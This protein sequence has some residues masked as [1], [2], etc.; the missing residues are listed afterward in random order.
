LFLIYFKE[1]INFTVYFRLLLDDQFR[2]LLDVH[3]NVQPPADFGCEYVTV[4]KQRHLGVIYHHWLKRYYV[5]PGIGDW[6][7][8]VW[9]WS[10]CSHNT[11]SHRSI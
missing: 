8:Y 10:K 7:A 3:C 4:D 2:L 11:K 5:T 9:I 6:Q 1:H